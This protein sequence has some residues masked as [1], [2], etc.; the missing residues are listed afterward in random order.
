MLE[1]GVAEVQSFGDFMDEDAPEDYLEMELNS[2][3]RTFARCAVLPITQAVPSR[4]ILGS[5]LSHVHARENIE[6]LLG[7]KSYGPLVLPRVPVLIDRKIQE[8]LLMLPE[9]QRR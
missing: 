4:P 5:T 3:M 1:S 7:D 9:R 8:H 2:E 6:V